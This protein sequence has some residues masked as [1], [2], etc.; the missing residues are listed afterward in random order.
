MLP[1]YERR[2]EC[3][4]YCGACCSMAHWQTHPL[5]GTVK[6]ILESP[7]FTG[8]NEFGECNHLRWK[9]GQAVCGIYETRPD[10][11][12]HFPNHPLSIETI[13]TCGFTFVATT[14]GAARTT[15]NEGVM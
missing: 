9:H 5:Y 2:G 13:P 12:R 10:I 6:E 1:M 3:N 7:P 11:C 14:E 8:M 4:R 15:R